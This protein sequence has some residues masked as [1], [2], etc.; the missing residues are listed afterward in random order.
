MLPLYQELDKFRP[1]LKNR[2]DCHVG[3]VFERFFDQYENNCQGVSIGK[4]KWLAGLTGH[5]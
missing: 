3:L 2:D 1:N 4:Q 5:N